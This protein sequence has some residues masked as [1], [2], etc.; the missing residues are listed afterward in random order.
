M[1]TGK[2]FSFLTALSYFEAPVR[3]LFHSLFVIA[4]L[5]KRINYVQRIVI[6]RLSA[7][8]TDGAM[9]HSYG[10]YQIG[11]VY[12]RYGKFAAR[13]LSAHFTALTIFSLAVFI[14][15]LSYISYILCISY[16]IHTF[17]AFHIQFMHFI[18][19]M[20]MVYKWFSFPKTPHL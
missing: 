5:H 18:Y 2:Q 11:Y 15:L 19:L 8:D 6:S 13:R 3:S 14:S 1:W 16:T 12:A 9:K 10:L 20:L 4:R 17:Y 7:K